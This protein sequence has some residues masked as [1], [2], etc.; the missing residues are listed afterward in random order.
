MASDS[1]GRDGSDSVPS[2]LYT[3][4][5]FTTDCEGY[6]KFLEGARELPARI[7][8][9]VEKAG[10]LRGKRVLDIGC[11]RGEL[12]CELASRGAY[13][14]GID[15]AEA[16]LELA[17]ELIAAAEP[18]L[19]ERV[20]FLRSD[21]KELPFGDDSFDTVFM[22]DVY[23][24]LHPHEITATLGEIKRI[25]RPGGLLVIH[26]GPNTWFYD[27]GYP[28]VRFVGRKL[29]G[30]KMRE[31]YRHESDHVLHVN[32]QSPLSLYRGLKSAGFRAR[33][34]PR[35]FSA[36]PQPPA[37]RR[38]VKRLLFARPFGYLFCQSLLAV[39][40]ARE[41]RSESQLRVES[42]FD[43]MGTMPQNKVLLI[44]EREGMLA[45]CLAAIGDVEVVWLE[46]GGAGEARPASDLF[47]T[48]GYTRTIGD[49][50]RLTYP[51]RHFD[52][53]ASQLTLEHLE[54]AQGVLLE[55]TR[56]LKNGGTLVLATRNRLFGGADQSPQPRVKQTYSPG[57]L[58]ELL[59]RT[60]LKVT[61]TS[62]LIPDLK[63]P[64]L[65][66]GDLSFSLFFEKLPYF[67]AR[68]KLLFVSAVKQG[69]GGGS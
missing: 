37:L 62:T 41:V 36:G 61:G 24:H 56:V 63:L 40:C 54:D 11:G 47:V 68:G 46:P 13:V 66:R 43:L 21:A 23:E 10:N 60:G 4:E 49:I 14:V 1:S 17:R 58:R 30:R 31:S 15:Y 32:E 29:L 50:Y 42:V 12:A 33:V 18:E 38:W 64:A 35:S 27:Y 5:Y 16:A 2:E 8:E 6:D 3:H 57:E 65:Y 67:R 53:I 52:C 45:A 59:E 39:A 55:W 22:V 25:L 19:Q 69:G 51:D 34:W 48:S 26:T 9:A 44:G 20:S 7:K 28:M